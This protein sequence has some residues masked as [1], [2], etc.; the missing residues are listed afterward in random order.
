[1]NLGIAASMWKH[2]AFW[3]AP[4][5]P[6]KF[7][8][9]LFKDLLAA[10]I[11]HLFFTAAENGAYQW[12]RKLIASDADFSRIQL[13]P[14]FGPLSYRQRVGPDEPNTPFMCG[15]LTA[16]AW[17]M[18]EVLMEDPPEMLWVADDVWQDL[19]H[20]S[21]LFRARCKEFLPDTKLI[22]SVT[23][24][25]AGFYYRPDALKNPKPDIVMQQAYVWLAGRPVMYSVNELVRVLGLCAEAQEAHGIDVGLWLSA[26]GP[27][28]GTELEGYQGFVIHDEAALLTCRLARIFGLRGPIA[29]FEMAHNT[30]GLDDGL[31]FYDRNKWS[32]ALEGGAS[33]TEALLAARRPLW[34][35]ARELT[36]GAEDE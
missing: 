3:N 28:A 23:T 8:R 4:A 22:T 7:Y 2:M 15:S 1:M 9:P 35:E 24:G 29:F 16:R 31:G 18:L 14:M 12:F 21:N 32:V 36:E 19:E 13:V 30:V 26:M 20:D 10:G 33:A 11:T 27:Y 6:G 25:G 17:T 5:G 34:D